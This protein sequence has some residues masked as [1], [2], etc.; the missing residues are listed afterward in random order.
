MKKIQISVRRLAEF[1]FQSGSIDSRLVTPDRALLGAKIHRQLQKLEGD[2]YEAEV[3]LKIEL[4][5]DGLQFVI[6]GRADGI[7]DGNK[8][9]EIKSTMRPYGEIEG[10]GYEVH[11]A[12]AVIYA[13]IYA[14][15][16]DR[17]AMDVQLRYYH[18]TEEMVTT[19]E[20]HYTYEE[21]QGYFDSLLDKYLVFA[22]FMTNWQERR[23]QSLNELTFPYDGYRKG[24]REL[25]IAVY[26]TVE[27]G[28]RLF[29]EAPT[30]I[31]KTMST[32]F[33]AFKAMG[34][35][36]TD[37]I[38][39]LTAKTITRQVAE[40]ALEELRRRGLRAKTVTLVAKD[41]ICFLN[42]RRCDPDH[43]P[44][45]NGYYDRLNEA[46][47]DLLQNEDALTRETIEHYAKKHVIC[48]FELSLDAALFCDV[49]TCDYNYLFDP[50]VYLRRFFSD[51]SG[52]YT[53]LVD[54]AHNLVDRAKKMY[55]AD[56]SLR[57]LEELHAEIAGPGKKLDKALAKL[58]QDM[59]AV[60]E[61]CEPGAGSYSQAEPFDSVEKD[62]EV[63]A[64]AVKE[65]LLVNPEAP[66]QEMV[67]RTFF[68]ANHF[69][70]ISELYS[71]KFVTLVAQ[72]DDTVLRLICLDPSELLEEKLKLGKAQ[73]LFSATFSPMDYYAGLLGG[74]D[75]EETSRMMFPSPFHPDRLKIIV[76]SHISTRYHA[77]KHSNLELAETLAAF[78]DSKQGN[79]LFFFPSYRYMEDVYY[80]FRELRPDVKTILQAPDLSEAEREAFLAEF[81]PDNEG[82]FVGFGILGGL[83]SEGVDLKGDRLIGVAVIGVGL[84]QP[85]DEQELVK[86]Y[87][88]ELNSQ[89][90]HYAYQIPGMNKVLQAG[91][92]VIR[93]EADHGALLLIDDRYTERR[94][95]ELFPRH[96]QHFS[97]VRSRTQLKEQLASFW[98]SLV[99]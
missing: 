46:L 45:A 89:G 16:E 82:T 31:G 76:D 10:D 68:A 60:G 8:I 7:V 83:F 95:Q 43:C 21:L 25:S 33:P 47:F 35:A 92:R 6:D 79:Y 49:I 38:F 18:I 44:F 41:K 77:R 51:Q 74:A 97:V 17:D 54:E 37:K 4:E 1:V 23:D 29:A 19:F 73:V 80:Q 36:K 67:L 62:L 57:Q 27:Q 3:S 94:Y 39:Y 81:Q 22:Q 48:P 52:D 93:G 15:Q 98:E 20:R 42:E 32:L 64:A 65:W 13:Y 50:T 78:A 40:D 84:A 11:W 9:D 66:G 90:F 85:S 28:S 53:F 87:Y 86:A 5:R 14:D 61:K 55:S 99:H 72:G 70:K 12:Q 56:L 91:G 34:E 88:D 63:F 58:V 71:D 59:K 24:Q 75:D 69:L 26:R 30:G 2:D 96:W